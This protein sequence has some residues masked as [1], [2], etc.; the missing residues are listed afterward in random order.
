MD[1]FSVALV[2]LF[3]EYHTAGLIQYVAFADW[4]LPLSNMHLSFLC[5]SPWLPWF[6]S[7]YY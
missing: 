2:L 5:V 7:L 4:M 6:I 3:I 1:L